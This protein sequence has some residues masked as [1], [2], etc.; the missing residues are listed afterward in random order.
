MKARNILKATVIAAAL[1]GASLA[2]AANNPLEP[3]YYAEKFAASAPVITSTATAGYRDLNNPLSPSY[4]RN[5]SDA[6]WV[7]TGDVITAPYDQSA[8]PLHPSFTR[9]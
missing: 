3:S 5:V 2:N 7:Q 9:R 6:G 4:A 1:A 8:N